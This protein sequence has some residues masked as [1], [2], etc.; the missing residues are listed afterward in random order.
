[1]EF[2]SQMLDKTQK[3]PL[4]QQLKHIL[5]KAIWDKDL[6]EG[7]T[8]PTE[9]T[10]AETLGI[11]RATVRQCMNELSNEG[12]IEKK[13]SRGTVV[14]KREIDLGLA[15]TASSFHKRVAGMGMEPR[16]ELLDLAVTTA[17]K[18]VARHLELKEGGRIIHL[19]RLR[20]VNNR[21]IMWTDSYLPYEMYFIL[22]HNFERESLY[23]IMDEREE[24]RVVRVNRDVY[25]R[26]AG[27]EMA[28]LYN[29]QPSAAMLAVDSVAY[30]AAGKRVEYSF[31][32][33]PGDS[34]VYS[35]QVYR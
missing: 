12:Y 29:I 34:N 26:F 30:N 21:P 23:E 15:D 22:G 16:T 32:L 3:R 9:D 13:R 10:L 18:K 20:Y 11:S 35:F 27:E 4:Y 19:E 17:S 24:S 2:S 1:M 28:K 33:S 7:D 8:L 31:S 25:A 6:V 14:L 5:L